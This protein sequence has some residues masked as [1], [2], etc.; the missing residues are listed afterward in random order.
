MFFQA[1][2][3]DPIVG[4]PADVNVMIEGKCL[5]TND[6]GIIDIFD[7]VTVSG[8]YGSTSE[9]YLD[10]WNPDA[11][12]NSDGVVD[13]FDI[14]TIAQKFG[15]ETDEYAHNCILTCP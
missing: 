15:C 14:V 11:D 3:D 7:V 12:F 5:D 6:D 13:I 8:A 10:W 2:Y 4:G 1:Y 9:D